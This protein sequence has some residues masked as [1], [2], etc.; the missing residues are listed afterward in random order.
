[1]TH[2]AV[3]IKNILY[4]IDHCPFGDILSAWLNPVKLLMPAVSSSVP[5]GHLGRS[6]KV[7]KEEGKELNAFPYKVEESSKRK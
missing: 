6:D 1:M 4:T 3:L 5:F 7:M 2:F